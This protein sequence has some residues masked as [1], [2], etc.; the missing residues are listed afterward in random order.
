MVVLIKEQIMAV[1]TGSQHAF[2]EVRDRLRDDI[3]HRNMSVGDRM[4]T[5]SQIA[6][7]Y[8]V[9]RNTA[10]R[11]V[12]ELVNA[13]VLE[14]RRRIGITVRSVS[15]FPESGVKQKSILSITRYGP[16]FVSK[17]ISNAIVEILPGWRLFHTDI[18][19]TESD[20]Y[21]DEFLDDFFDNNRYEAYLLYSVHRK[22]KEYFQK[23]QLPCVVI[24]GEEEGIDLPNVYT[25]E[26]VR[27]F[28]IVKFLLQNGYPNIAF[29]Q[30]DKK[31]PGDVQRE[32]AVFAAYSES[33][34][35]DEI[36]KPFVLNIDETDKT[37]TEEKLCEFLQETE[38]PVGVA[39]CSDHAACWLLQKA[40][41]MG[42]AI[43]EQLGIVTSGIS[44][45][46]EHTYPQITSLKKYHTQLG[47]AIGKMLWQII[48][49]YELE[50]R[51]V[52]LSMEAP[53]IEERQTTTE[54]AMVAPL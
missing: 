4:P 43:P 48:G 12:T 30:F 33:C 26:Y 28:E 20:N 40:Q 13:G 36:I 54:V 22:L 39:L 31:R 41:E 19:G 42:I 8:D 7:K 14:S 3:R 47:F 24:G 18:G 37:G 44:D 49:G 35:G 29:V 52:M 50:S 53:F 5:I 51:H 45:L 16:L 27:Y 34:D 6:R 21:S 17:T 38:F 11:A 9:S 10:I 2:A 1:L 46:P 25:D 15:P 23:R 32:A